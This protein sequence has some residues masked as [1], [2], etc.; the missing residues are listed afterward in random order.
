MRRYE[1]TLGFVFLATR[2]NTDSVFVFIA[3]SSPLDE[4]T[5]KTRTRIQFVPFNPN[6]HWLSWI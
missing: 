1:K 4:L 6:L 5:R 3:L 2:V